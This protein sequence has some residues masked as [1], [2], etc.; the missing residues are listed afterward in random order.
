MVPLNIDSVTPLKNLI[1][2]VT[3]DTSIYTNG[4]L[5]S[6]GLP[7]SFILIDP[8]GGIRTN[9]S[10]FGNA[11]CTLSVSIY[12]SLLSTGA[13]NI[14]KENMIVDNFQSLF[15]DILKAS[16]GEN[17]FTYELASTPMMY[18]GKS[19]ISGYSTKIININSFIN[20]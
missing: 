9:A 1:L 7:G 4:G 14:T 12:V 17:H 13:T 10:K 15:K 16:T 20:Y 5:P 6:S 19:L 2:S 3:S 18:S 8:N 11:L